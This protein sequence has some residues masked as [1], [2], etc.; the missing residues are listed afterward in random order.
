M[1][2][3]IRHHAA[4]KR[5]QPN[6]ASRGRAP[7]PNTFQDDSCSSC[8]DAAGVVFQGGFA[9]SANTTQVDD[10]ETTLLAALL[11]RSR[12]YRTGSEYRQLLDFI[13]R[14]RH[15]APF[16]AA[17]LHIQK[18]GLNFAATAEDWKARFGREVRVGVRPLLIMWPFSP[19]ALVYDVADTEGPALPVD[20]A[21][22]FRAQ[23][24]IKAQQ[25][26]NMVQ[27]LSRMKIACHDVDAA[28]GMA[29]SV[30]LESGHISLPDG[31]RRRTY[32]IKLNAHHDPNVRFATLAHELGHLFLGHLGADEHLGIKDRR[33]FSHPQREL[34]AEMVSYLVCRRQ[35]VLSV[36]EAYLAA[37]TASEAEVRNLD[38][39][40]V[41]TAAGRV[42]T[43][44]AVAAVLD[45]GLDRKGR[46]LSGGGLQEGLLLDGAPSESIALPSPHPQP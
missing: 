21:E 5:C 34:E 43:S 33:G 30:R 17:L 44:V 24:P 39:H 20:V 37:F 28:S 31:K 1:V 9:L 16:N 23:G 29:G 32:T 40:C 8:F 38:I 45:V 11:E 35:G 3:R 14:M 26:A 18:P 27:A 22:P 13:C 7:I 19:V 36:S 2:A 10:R 4:A 12:I 41:T 42:E 15:M 6:L 46:T 25:L